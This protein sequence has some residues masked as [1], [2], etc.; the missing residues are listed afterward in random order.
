[1][2]VLVLLA[3]AQAADF[4]EIRFGLSSGLE[5]V[6]NDP[7]VIRNG[8]RLGFSVSPAPWVEVGLAGVWFPI[9]GASGSAD[10]PDWTP[11]TKQLLTENSVSPDISKLAFEIQG[12][13]RIRALSYDYSAWTLSM[14]A[15]AGAAVVS[16]RDDPYALQVDASDPTFAATANQWHPG[17]VGGLYWDLGIRYVAFRLRLEWVGY[18]ET[19]NSTTLEMKNNA[20]LGGEVFVWF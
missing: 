4:S 8:A 10:D 12:V 6:T 17:P 20:L 19:I 18:T 1:M 14:G 2:I 15:F 16:T 13:L 9:L 7:F 3:H 11:L 5:T